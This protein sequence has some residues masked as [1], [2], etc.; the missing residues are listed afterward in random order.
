MQTQMTQ[1]WPIYNFSRLA[2]RLLNR[3]KLPGQ[4]E[5]ET[6]NLRPETPEKKPS[7]EKTSNQHFKQI[8]ILRKEKK[9]IYFISNK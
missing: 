8:R 7:Q 5:F 1:M 4:S 2:H 9:K 6:W 3:F